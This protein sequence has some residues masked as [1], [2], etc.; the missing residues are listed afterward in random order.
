MATSHLERRVQV[1]WSQ[2]K[3]GGP[4]AGEP[5]P[6]ANPFHSERVKTEVELI[7]SRPVSLDKDAARLG[8]DMDAQ[9]L[10]EV[11]TDI[12]GEPDYSAV[13]G[14][15]EVRA[16]PRVA[17]VEATQSSSTE[18]GQANVMT[19]PRQ[20]VA[21]DKAGLAT[22][23]FVATG[24]ESGKVADEGGKGALVGPDPFT[25]AGDDPRELIPDDSDRLGRFEVLLTQVLEE[26][27]Q[28]KRR[29]EQT[30]SRS[31][32]SYHSGLAQLDPSF[33]PGY[34]WTESECGC[35]EVSIC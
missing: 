2:G 7:R 31:H 6:V 27:R 5:L 29:L 3:R 1:C 8:V 23:C 15:T 10:G 25:E 28:L 4:Q 17:R 9:D 34:V 24:D 11:G 35:T 14:S 30:E 22:P 33:S 12:R 21:R 20:P 32:S 18:V 16:P 13:F 26:N 19:E